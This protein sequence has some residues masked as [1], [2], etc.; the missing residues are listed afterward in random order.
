MESFK[1][2]NLLKKG[3]KHLLKLIYGRTMMILILMVFQ[4]GII[5]GFYNFLSQYT[6]FFYGVMLALTIGTV[7][8]IFNNHYDDSV[9]LS[10]MLPVTALAPFGC[11]FYLYV[12]TDAGHRR[13]KKRMGQVA[14]EAAL[15]LPVA[16]EVVDEIKQKSPQLYGLSEYCISA[17]GYGPYKNSAVT[18][19]PLGE[20]MLEDLLVQLEMA[21]HFIF[22]EYFII[23]EG[24]MWGKVLNLLS[25]K[26]QQGVEV[27]I[28][29]DGMNEFANLPHS[30][31]KKLKKLGIQCKIFAPIRPFVSTEYNYRDHRKIL[32]IDGHTAFT[33]G[34]NMADEYINE[35]ERFGH[36]KDT[37]VMIQGDGA[38]GFTRMFLEAWH[39]TETE[40][41]Y[42]KYLFPEHT[43]KLEQ[44]TPGYVIPYADSPLD[45]DKVG[46]LVYIDIINT[47]KQYVHIMTPYLILDGNMRSA[48]MFAARRGVDVKLILPHIPDKK[49]AFALAKSHYK[50][51]TEAGVEIYEY[52]PGFVH[53]KVFVSDNHKAVVGSINLDYRSLYHHF[54]CALYMDGV[55]AIDDIEADYQKTLQSCQLITVED[56]RNQKL[57]T[58]LTGRL[59]KLLAPL[60]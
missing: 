29:Y 36:W 10:W 7:I 59:L 9:K 14:V 56:I 21:Q 33:G 15:E 16:E 32:V 18:Y 31:P 25:K 12:R 50:D 42:Q 8:E 19:Y 24:H 3:K 2:L 60:L 48:L 22:L 43:P 26:A 35:I 58:R 52:T 51:L 11:L 40:K 53:A 1:E 20:D 28:I 57:F 45:G 39:A 54:E 4:V 13:L 30:Y 38:R 23:Q 27:R 49:S 47:A 6:S 17:G 5:I 37:A 46:E 55:T 44:K 41:N 34:V